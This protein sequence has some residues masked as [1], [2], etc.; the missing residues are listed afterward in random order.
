MAIQQATCFITSD[1]S[2]FFDELEAE[3]HE[4]KT[5]VAFDIDTFNES[6]EQ[7][8][9]A[10]ALNLLHSTLPQFIETMGYIKAPEQID[11]TGEV[12]SGEAAT[13]AEVAY[14]SGVVNT[15]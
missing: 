11:F 15:L 9:N 4:S 10:R 14:I 13:D 8:L 2:T 3:Q 5:T 1:G 12:V 6:L 7:P